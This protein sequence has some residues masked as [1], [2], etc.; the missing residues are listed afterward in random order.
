VGGGSALQKGCGAVVKRTE[1]GTRAGGG[2]GT[3]EGWGQ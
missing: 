1:A 3:G 2:G